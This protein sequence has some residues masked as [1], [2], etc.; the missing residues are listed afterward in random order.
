MILW[1]GRAR[2]GDGEPPQLARRGAQRSGGAQPGRDRARC[3]RGGRGCRRRASARARGRRARARAPCRVAIAITRPLPCRMRPATGPIR[4]ARARSAPPSAGGRTAASHAPVRNRE[5]RRSRPGATSGARSGRIVRPTTGRASDPC[6]TQTRRRAEVRQAPRPVEAAAQ[7]DRDVRREVRRAQRDP[8]ARTPLGSIEARARC[9]PG[10]PDARSRPGERT[11][12]NRSTRPPSRRER[13]RASSTSNPRARMTSA[14]AG[15]PP[16][17]PCRRGTA[18]RPATSEA[19]GPARRP[20]RGRRERNDERQR[21][22]D[23]RGSR[24]PPEDVDR[25]PVRCERVHQRSV[26]G[27]HP[28]AAV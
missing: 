13:I 3:G 23:E 5:R 14:P 24:L 25:R 17:A 6:M 18:R 10:A 4:P 20:P 8:R 11:S 22:R 19:R 7:D 15:R 21:R 28:D 12:T 2:P 16:A 26:A 9:Q 1:L 27:H